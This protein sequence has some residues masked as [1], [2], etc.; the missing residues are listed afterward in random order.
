MKRSKRCLIALAAACG[1]SGGDVLAQDLSNEKGPLPTLEV[2]PGGGKS[3]RV[4]VLR[5]ALPTTT[6]SALCRSA[7]RHTRTT[8]HDILHVSFEFSAPMIP[9]SPTPTLA[10]CFGCRTMRR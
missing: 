2:T 7:P 9:R 6:I 3:F 1:L 5:V 10:E 8:R 4:A